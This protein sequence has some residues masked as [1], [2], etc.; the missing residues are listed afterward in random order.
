MAA[1]K[2]AP[3]GVKADGTP[4]KKPG[5]KKG[6]RQQ[7]DL[8]KAKADSLL[9]KSKAPSRTGRAAKDRP[10]RRART[11][12]ENNDPILVN[13]FAETDRAFVSFLA[14]KSQAARV[15]VSDARP[16]FYDAAKA[17]GPWEP[18]ISAILPDGLDL[19]GMI[20]WVADNL[21]PGDVRTYTMQCGGLMNSLEFALNEKGE[22]IPRPAVVFKS[23]PRKVV[24]PGSPAAV[25]DAMRQMINARSAI[26]IIADW[27]M[28]MAKPEIVDAATDARQAIDAL[29]KTYSAS[30]EEI[31]KAMGELVPNLRK[32]VLSVVSGMNDKEK[33]ILRKRGVLK[34][35]PAG[36][37]TP[38]EIRD[39]AGRSGRINTSE[40]PAAPH[41]PTA[42]ECMPED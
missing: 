19:P 6:Q 20:R 31:E 4:R 9:F 8:Q 37:I 38:D 22:R 1:K 35:Q 15:S 7:K 24:E 13:P 28:T 23:V 42:N 27:G 33:D 2:T 32:S 3:Y 21:H 41:V 25:L 5:P 26:G 36:Q 34:D 17:T 14:T 30:P 40:P 11:R 18:S 39:E 29:T 12:S 16:E 10:M